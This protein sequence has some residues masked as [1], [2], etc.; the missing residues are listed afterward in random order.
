V[1]IFIVRTTWFQNYEKMFPLLDKFSD[2]KLWLEDSPDT[3]SDLDVWG[4]KKV[5]YTFKDLLDL[6][7]RG[8]P[9]VEDSEE[10]EV[11]P[12]KRKGKEWE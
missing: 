5:N 2:V 1:E 6:V 4:F 7:E 10:E 12:R 9:L 8:G 3:P 11:V